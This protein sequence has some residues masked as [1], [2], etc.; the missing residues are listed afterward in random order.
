MSWDDPIVDVFLFSLHQLDISM[1]H[2]IEK[3]ILVEWKN[4]VNSHVDH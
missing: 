2:H 4:S 3:Q 1:D